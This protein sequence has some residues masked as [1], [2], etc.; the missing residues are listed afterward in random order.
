VIDPFG[1]PRGRG[2]PERLAELA[3]LSAPDA[4]DALA[5]RLEQASAPIDLHRF[6][7]ARNLTALETWRV[8]QRQQA[9]TIIR[10]NRTVDMATDPG[11]G[12]GPGTLA[13]ASARHRALQEAVVAALASIHETAPDQVGASESALAPKLGRRADD[14]LLKA[15][16]L[17]LLDRGAVVHDGFWL[18]LP[19]HRPR[20]SADDAALLARVGA[21]LK[22]NGLRPPI[23][24]ELATALGCALPTL[25]GQLT[26]L[27]RR[28]H[29]VQVA[30]NRFFAPA[31]V[32][33]LAQIAAELVAATPTLGFDAATYRDRTGL[34]R[35]LTIEVLEFLD[36]SGVTR[37]Q[38]G[39]R[40]M[41]S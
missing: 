24:G 14:A 23:V 27:A 35:N 30:K 40:R 31:T 7:Q 18:R 34:G 12:I 11:H 6:V 39:R 25:L 19:D 16:V 22:A 26:D 29:L 15:A 36:R 1:W 37:F 2:R 13:I 9:I 38:Q 33:E 41:I 20:L 8:L 21:V 17:A 28:G 10:A 32:A 4:A 3:A 5:A